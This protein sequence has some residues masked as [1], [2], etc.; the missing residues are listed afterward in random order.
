MLHFLMISPPLFAVKG[1]EKFWGLVTYTNHYQDVLFLVE[2]QIRLV[3]IGDGYEQFLLNTGAGK[4]FAPQLQ[5]WVGQ[6]ISNFS[7]YNIEE[8]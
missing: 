2:P 1:F 7:P 5:L 3:N 4:A 6:T 8:D